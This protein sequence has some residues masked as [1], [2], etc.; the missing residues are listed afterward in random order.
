MDLAEGM[1]AGP[2]EAAD[3][4]E[5]VADALI[6][7]GK[8]DRPSLERARRLRRERGSTAEHLHILLT[9]LGLVAEAD[10]AAALAEVLG[11]PLIGASDFPEEAVLADV[12]SARFLKEAHVIPLAADDAGI[13]VAMAN[14]LDAFSRQAVEIATHRPVRAAVALPAD[15]E[16]AFER[17]YGSGGTAISQLVDG[18]GETESGERD[19]DEER[20]KD[21]ASEAPVIRLVNLLVSRAV[22]ARASDIHI[23]PYE[24]TL[25]VRYRID[26]VLHEVETPPVKLRSAIVSRVKI[27]AKLNIAERR[28]PQDGRVKLAVRGK[29]VDFRVSTLPTMHGESV[30]LRILDKGSAKFEFAVLGFEE[31]TL[32]TYL[33]VLERPNG[34]LL[35]TGP[36]GSG[37]TTTL[38]T[39]LLRLNTPD[40]KILTVEDP[41]EYQLDG[42]NQIQVK[43]KI[44]LT[45]ANVLR[46]ILRQDPDIIMIGEIRDLETAQIAAQSALTGHLVLS[47]LHTNSAAGTVTRLLDMG[48]EDYLLASTVNGITAQRLVR[49]LCPHC[50]IAEPATE[51]LV[52][53]LRLER[54]AQ[55]GTP[56]LRYRAV[57]CDAC[58][59]TGYHGRS[60][61]AEMLVIDEDIR[62]MTL[63]KADA[64]D[65]QRQ[66]VEAGMRTLYDDGMR[67]ALAG[68]TSIEE[69]LRVTRET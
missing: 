34:I 66:A 36:T 37:K 30:V 51:E 45:F 38:Y 39:S 15:I 43:P 8:L 7:C 13:R 16:R 40:K 22:E 49:R 52:A 23:E 46:S 11:L 68:L 5:A 59:G 42:V 24:N 57:G 35:V 41:I 48:L 20:L 29:E 21:Q 18:L 58:N 26:G 62:R 55:P 69:V 63:R 17:L 54:F 12:L 1:A 6:G 50:R 27:M 28:L 4:E 14:P 65:I 25:R 56:I 32:E 47:T 60:A 64:R 53:E 2:V 44:G 61:I 10:V 67:K 3:V 19:E 9:Q 33:D 31:D